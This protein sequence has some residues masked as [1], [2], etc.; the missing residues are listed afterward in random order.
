MSKGKAA[1]LPLTRL[2]RRA[3]ENYL[4]ILEDYSN[5]RAAYLVQFDVAKGKT[6]LYG[7]R[8]YMP[9]IKLKAILLAADGL[10]NKEISARLEV[11]Q[12]TVGKWRADFLYVL[13]RTDYPFERI[14]DFFLYRSGYDYWSN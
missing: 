12:H 8:H 14:K 11:S 2:E 6:G 7:D 4:P 1:E 3:L 5:E 9:I 13:P 10:S